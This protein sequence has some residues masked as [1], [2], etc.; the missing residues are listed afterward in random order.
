[1][2]T[3]LPTQSWAKCKATLSE[4]M[5]ANAA[6]ISPNFSWDSH[7]I[8]MPSNYDVGGR[9]A[10]K[11]TS[12]ENRSGNIEFDFA[13]KKTP[14]FDCSSSNAFQSFKVLLSKLGRTPKALQKLSIFL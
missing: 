1:M 9:F 12:R 5:F 13:I 3:T 8:E 2:Q 10:I 4:R 6:A 11:E 14:E 7:Q